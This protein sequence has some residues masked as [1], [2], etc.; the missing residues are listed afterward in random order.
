MN[1]LRKLSATIDRSAWTEARVCDALTQVFREVDTDFLAKYRTALDG[2]TAVVSLILGTA[3]FTAWAGDSRAVL[4]QQRSPDDGI[5]TIPL[6]DDHRPGRE[7]EADRVAQA[8]GTV[9]DLNEGAWRVAHMGFEERVREI[10][11]AEQQGLGLIGK[12]PTALA[13]SSSFGDRD[14]KPVTCGKEIITVT[15]EV[16]CMRLDRSHKFIA[17][18]CDGIPDVME[19]ESIVF[20]LAFVRDPSNSAADTK[21]ACKALVQEAYN[22][23]SGDNMSVILAR[24]QWENV[25]LAPPAK[26]AVLRAGASDESAVAALKRKHREGAS[27]NPESTKAQKVEKEAENFVQAANENAL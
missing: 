21:L 7:S 27:T 17:L 11:R 23:G 4:C 22:R 1:L 10:R 8:G 3:L 12:E 24:F 18:V 9:V 6:T 20:D 14:F 13:V 25:A 15:P 2:T 19:N 26:P 5:G 16:Q